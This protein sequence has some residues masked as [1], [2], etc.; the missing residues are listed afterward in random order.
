MQYNCKNTLNLQH[1]LV[2]ILVIYIK[3]T[4]P[5]KIGLVFYSLLKV[6]F[7]IVSDYNN[8][9]DTKLTKAHSQLFICAY[10]SSLIL[11]L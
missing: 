2:F 8:E 7:A 9:L 4:Y 6:V 3:K 11:S 10:V 5:L 1:C